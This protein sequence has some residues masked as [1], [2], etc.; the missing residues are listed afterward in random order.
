MYLLINDFMLIR[1]VEWYEIVMKGVGMVIKMY[2]FFMVYLI[3]VLY[4]FEVVFD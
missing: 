1:C 3:C 4:M 2:G